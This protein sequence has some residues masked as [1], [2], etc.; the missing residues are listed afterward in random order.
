MAKVRKFYFVKLNDIIENKTQKSYTEDIMCVHIG[1][2]GLLVELE[3][4]HKRP[5]ELFLSFYHEYNAHSAYLQYRT[6][7]YGKFIENTNERIVFET[8]KSTYVFSVV[9]NEMT[10]TE[11]KLLY[12]N[13]FC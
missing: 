3:S 7:S 9:E 13:V 6:T 1:Y 8:E 10:D 5:G 4:E 11:K 2:S 12:I